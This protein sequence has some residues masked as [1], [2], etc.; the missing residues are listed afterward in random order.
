MS[1]QIQFTNNLN[2]LNKPY[3]SNYPTNHPS[4]PFSFHVEDKTE[5]K[6]K[7]VQSRKER[8]SKEIPILAYVY[9]E[10][11]PAVTEASAFSIVFLFFHISMC[12]KGSLRIIACE[13]P[14]S[15]LSFLYL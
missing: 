2:L 11:H 9:M 1:F 8:E 15:S 3:H 14:N 4:L 12:I 13:N 10:T 7:K 5:V 6:K